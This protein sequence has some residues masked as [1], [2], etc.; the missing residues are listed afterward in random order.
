MTR[1]E[2]TNLRVI[3][4]TT[5]GT[6]STETWQKRSVPIQIETELQIARTAREKDTGKMIID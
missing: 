4:T 5:V 6:E 3:T 1:M 2:F